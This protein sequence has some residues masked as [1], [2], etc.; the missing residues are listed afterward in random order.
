M[1]FKFFFLIFIITSCRIDSD[2]VSYDKFSTEM[3]LSLTQIEIAD[4]VHMRYPFKI[5]KSDSFFFILDLH[6]PEYFVHCYSFPNFEYVHSFFK[7]GQGP[8]EYIQIEN[9]QCI[10]DSLL[11][12][13][14][15]S[16]YYAAIQD[17]LKT[18]FV[19]Q[20]INFSGDFGFLING[21]KI[22][23]NFYFPAF[24]TLQSGR[25]LAFDNNGDFNSSFGKLRLKSRKVDAATYQGWVSWLAGNEDILVTATQLGEVIDIYSLKNTQ[26]QFTI[27]GKGGFP[28]FQ[29]HNGYGI[30]TGIMGFECVSVTKDYIIAVYNGVKLQSRDP[31]KEGGQYIYI[32]DYSGTPIKKIILDQLIS[33]AYV[34]EK[35]NVIYALTV[36]SNQ[37]LFMAKLP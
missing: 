10:N 7:R 18:N 36:N 20:K 9:I 15:N 17:L 35:D 29:K 11:I 19:P 23:N 5:A 24:N 12:F 32:Y 34:D 2:V 28:V 8:N 14:R 13:D 21:I 26:E 22:G 4:S 25:L 16:A 33:Y 30:P 1:K 37:P 31:D 6:A 3:A 27:K